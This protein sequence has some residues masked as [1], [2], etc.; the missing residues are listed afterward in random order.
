MITLRSHGKELVKGSLNL[1]VVEHLVLD[2][3]QGL[4]VARPSLIVESPTFSVVFQ[5]CGDNE[6]NLEQLE[7]CLEDS[8]RVIGLDS[9]I[10]RPQ[11][12]IYALAI[13]LELIFLDENSL[14][15]RVVEV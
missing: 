13:D 5:L 11:E 8:T 2:C 7:H 9:N 1:Q 6:S 14:K 4:R 15:V 12:Q 10:E 3:F